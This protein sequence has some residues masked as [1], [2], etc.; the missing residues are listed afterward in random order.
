MC[1]LMNQE[2][3]DAYTCLHRLVVAC[4]IDLVVNSCLVLT[5]SSLFADPTR[6]SDVGDSKLSFLTAAQ[7]RAVAV[8]TLVGWC[9]SSCCCHCHGFTHVPLQRL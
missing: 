2:I 6:Q 9:G 1:Q 5:V 7:P 8:W 3:R 4:E